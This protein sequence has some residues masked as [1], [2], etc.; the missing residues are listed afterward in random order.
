MKVF[1]FNRKSIALSGFGP[2]QQKNNNC[3]FNLNQLGYTMMFV[4]ALNSVGTYVYLEASDIALYMD[5]FF[6]L[7]V[8]FWICV[9]HVSLIL[10]NDELFDAIDDVEKLVNKSEYPSC[11]IAFSK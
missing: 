11:H 6:I 5:S 2:D 4:I 7:A 8:G 10:K 3:L 1:Q 9:C